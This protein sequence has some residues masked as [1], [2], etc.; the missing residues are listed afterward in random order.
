MKYF[1][2][3]IYAIVIMTIVSCSPKL[4]PNSSLPKVFYPEI[5]DSAKIQ[6]LTSYSFVSD[7]EKKQSK[8][9]SAIVG[10]QQDFEIKKPYGVEIH[11]NKIYVCDIG[12]GGMIII[13]LEKKTFNSFRP[14]GNGNLLMPVNSAI[15]EEEN[16]YVAD[17]KAQKILKYDS[18]GNYLLNFGLNENKAPSDVFIKHK[19]VWVCDTKN[20][21]VNVYDKE[22]NKFLY[23]VF[24]Y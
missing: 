5:A 21:R 14:Q 19:K 22:N 13:D 24:I 1:N 7:I 2:A 11:N 20:N 23:I 8:F 17:I 18:N 12:I 10:E 16:L 9:N 4:I 6:F 3:I 15:D